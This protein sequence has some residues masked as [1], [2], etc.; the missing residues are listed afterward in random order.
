MVKIT[1]YSEIDPTTRSYALV[2]HFLSSWA[3]MEHELDR[4]IQD[5]LDLTFL[6]MLIVTRNVQFGDKIHIAKTLVDVA[7]ITPPQDKKIFQA[8]LDKI[9]DFSIERNLAAH[10]MFGPPDSGEGVEFLKVGAKGKLKFPKI[11]WTSDAT[12]DRC[13]L[14]LQYKTTLADLRAR[15]KGDALSAAI[16]AHPSPSGTPAP[17]G[18]LG[19]LGLLPPEPHSS[20]TDVQSPGSKGTPS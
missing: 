1:P 18:L 6:Q 4:V 7:S 19:L 11:V 10:E 12:L 5:G 8:T 15:I 16:A 17:L 2:G 13:E 20:D 9:K 14:C 3:I